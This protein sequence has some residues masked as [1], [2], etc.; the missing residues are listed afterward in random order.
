MVQQGILSLGPKVKL[1]LRVGAQ[2][3]R[4]MIKSDLLG[5]VLNDAFVK[6]QIVLRLR[7]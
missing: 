6:M 3:P 5:R 4:A 2:R 7:F 1:F